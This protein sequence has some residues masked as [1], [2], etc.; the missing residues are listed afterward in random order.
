MEKFREHEKEFKLNKLTKTALQNISETESKFMFEDEESN[1]D[2]EDDGNSD[3]G[4]SCSDE[5]ILT[6]KDWLARFLSEH[7]KKLQTGVELELTEIKNKKKSRNSKNK[8]KISALMKKLEGWKKVRDRAEE[9]TLSTDY[10]DTGVL[11]ELRTRSRHF[12][13]SPEDEELRVPVIEEIEMLIEVAEQN[14][15]KQT[16]F[17]MF[18]ASQDPKLDKSSDSIELC[19]APDV[20]SHEISSFESLSLG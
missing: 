5:E 6:D 4:G 11:K 13:A 3:G 17:Q 9:L 19:N 8:D 16:N 2:D 18:G 1:S 15:R 7:L 14:R 12:L 10:L 20:M